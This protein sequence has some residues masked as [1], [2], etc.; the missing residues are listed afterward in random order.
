MLLVVV[1]FICQ[2]DKTI[3]LK[4]LIEYQSECCCEDVIF[5]MRLAFKLEGFE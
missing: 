5:N 4:Y 1:N 2:L 3:V